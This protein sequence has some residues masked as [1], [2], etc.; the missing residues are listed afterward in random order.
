MSFSYEELNAAPAEDSFKNL[1]DVEVT[2]PNPELFYGPIDANPW[3]DNDIVDFSPIG[4]YLQRSPSMYGSDSS[5]SSSSSSSKSTAIV[6]CSWNDTGFT[7][8]FIAEMPEVRFDDHFEISPK[9][10]VSRTPIDPKFIEVCEADTIRVVSAIGSNGVV[11]YARVE[12]GHVVLGL[13]FFARPSKVCV[14]LSGIRHGFRNMRF[15]DRTKNQFEHNE[16]FINSAY[17]D[18]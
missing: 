1:I 8:L 6:P 2:T 17:P 9:Q 14:R 11:K 3:P 10:R 7:A 18:E 16:R 5:S 13:P 4:L 15:P 12:D